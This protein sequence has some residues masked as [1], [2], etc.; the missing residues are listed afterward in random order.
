MQILIVI[1]LFL[2][3]CLVNRKTLHWEMRTRAGENGK[4]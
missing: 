1:L 3:S 4:G 2:T